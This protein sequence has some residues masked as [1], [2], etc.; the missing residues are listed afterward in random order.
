V[1]IHQSKLAPNDTTR[2]AQLGPTSHDTENIRGIIKRILIGNE[3]EVVR[4]TQVEY[5]LA[6]F[7]DGPQKRTI[8]S[9]WERVLH[10]RCVH[11]KAKDQLLLTGLGG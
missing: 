1:S 4:G 10:M 2:A 8:A 9:F 7:S 5:K 6:F 3:G 11:G